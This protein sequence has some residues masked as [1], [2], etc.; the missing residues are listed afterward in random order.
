M[1][2]RQSMSSIIAATLHIY[3]RIVQLFVPTPLTCHYVFSIRD[4]IRLFQGL[5]QTTSERFDTIERFVRVWLHECYR[6]FADRLIN[7]IDRDLFDECVRTMIDNHTHWHIHRTYLLRMPLM[8]GDYR[9][10]HTSNEPNIYEDLQD[11]S[12]IGALIHDILVDFQQENEH[13]HIVLFNDALEH[14]TRIYRVLRLD[15]AHLLLI[16]VSNAGKQLLSKMACFIARY[17]IYEIELT[18]YYNEQTFLDDLKRMF[19]RLGLNNDRLAF[20]LHDKHIVDECFLDYINCILLNGF[21]P[22]LFTNDVRYIRFCRSTMFNTVDCDSSKERDIIVNQLREQ[23][24]NMIRS[25]TNETIWST[26]IQRCSNNLH[27]ILCLN[28]TDE[29]F[30]H[31]LENELLSTTHVK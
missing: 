27:I 4:L 23:D 31:R 22:M 10:V 5:V 13:E 26:F 11:Y 29:R 30:R 9:T 6:V 16:G 19:N 21:I 24:M 14:L 7:Q 3:D 15:R 18:Q 28:S 2:I 20:I 12:A 1:D 17:S 25:R 8:F